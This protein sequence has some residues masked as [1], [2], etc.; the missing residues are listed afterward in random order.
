MVNARRSGK[1]RDARCVGAEATRVACA[2]RPRRG[3]DDTLLD[4]RG[5]RFVRRRGRLPEGRR[6]GGN[7]ALRAGDGADVIQ[8]FQQG[9]DKVEFENGVPGFG[10]LTIEQQ[11]D[12]V[13]A[14]YARG[15]IILES[16]NA[17]AIG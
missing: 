7:V 16:Q 4:L 2:G 15:S 6:R 3:V 14:S 5:L 17:E 9:A 1:C 11:G 8:R 12:N 13:L 10:S